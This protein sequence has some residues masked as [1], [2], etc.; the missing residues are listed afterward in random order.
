M[1]GAFENIYLCK[2]SLAAFSW[3]IKKYFLQVSPYSQ[4]TTPAI[5]PL[6][7][8]TCIISVNYISIKVATEA[9]THKLAAE[10][11]GRKG[12]G[13]GRGSDNA[14]LKSCMPYQMGANYNSSFLL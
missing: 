4:L 14:Q 13:G 3:N 2:E 10:G 12:G 6:L 1:Y 11:E 7:C 8:H 9:R 5:L